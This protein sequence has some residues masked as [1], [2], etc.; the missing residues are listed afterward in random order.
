VDL[1]QLGALP[2]LSVRQPWASY[3]VSGLKS[4][5]LRRWSTDYRGWLWIHTGK[6]LDLEALKIFG[7]SASDFR[8]GGLLGIAKLASCTLIRN[9]AEWHA[10][11]NEHRSPGQFSEGVYAWL[12][13]DTVALW[14]KIECRG[15][16]GLFRLDTLTRERV[17]NHLMNAPLQQDFVETVRDLPGPSDE[18]S[19]TP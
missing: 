2:V 11:R 15:E 19:E 1:K 4:V 13:R 16:L 18:S 17:E 12:F 7:L 10:R 5:E 9:A 8:T 6:Q 14:E 3:I